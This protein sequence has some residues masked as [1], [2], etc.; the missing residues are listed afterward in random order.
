M[1]N[2]EDFIIS[3]PI[4]LLLS[5]LLISGISFI[6]SNIIRLTGFSASDVEWLKFQEPIIGISFISAFLYPLA[7]FSHLNYVTLQILAFIIVGAGLIYGIKIS[8][9]LFTKNQPKIR[10]SYFNSNKILSIFIVFLILGYFLFSIG[11]TTNADSIDYHVGIA[12]SIIN[13]GG[14]PVT[15][16]WFHS[17]L[18]GS[19]EALNALGLVIG[20]E[21][22]GPLMQFFGLISITSIIY[23][24]K[25]NDELIEKDKKWKLILTLALLSSP[26]FIFLSGSAKPQLLPLAMTSLAMTLLINP[27]FYAYKAK[28][29]LIN[30]TLICMLVMSA[31]QLKFLYLLGGG[32]V[33]ITAYLIMIKNGQ[34]IKATIIGLCSFALIMMPPMVWKIIYYDSSIIG[35]II[36][37]F[38]GG[39]P[40]YDNFENMLRS[41]SDGPLPFPLFLILP[42]SIG[43]FTMIIGIGLIFSLFIKI[44]T[45]VNLKIAFLLSLFVLVFMAIFGSN[46]TRHFLEPFVWMLIALSIQGKQNTNIKILKP[47][48]V[49][50]IA[51]STGVIIMLLIGIISTLP[52]IFSKDL[53][54]DVLKVNANG[55]DVM[56][57]A[58]S[59]LTKDDVILIP[60]RSMSFSN[61]KLI[62]LDW[63]E[64]TE[65]NDND[66]LIYLEQIRKSKASHVIIFEDDYKQS[67]I[68]NAFEEC[69]GEEAIGPKDNILATRNPF[70][71]TKNKNAWILKFNSNKLPACYLDKFSN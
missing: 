40:G 68:Y 37:A 36:S 42:A 48:N 47:M 12:I 17:R 29:K 54:H 43:K 13:N 60:N 14:I 67:D 23:F 63:M 31:I 57:W 4:S 66:P 39:L 35:S 38:P 1:Y 69:I 45:K 61:N 58:N 15:P 11:P 59:I 70:N 27:D 34:F 9:L 3:N 55:Y 52:G 46:T 26:I 8:K 64:Y 44:P 7:L 22:F 25:G 65:L 56:V 2:L 33:G 49:L 62:S 21:Q 6:G 53:R 32:V 10:R 5:L 28:D 50:L 24:I 41:Y 51:Q 71:R 16:E 19:G 20:A 18:A 30:F